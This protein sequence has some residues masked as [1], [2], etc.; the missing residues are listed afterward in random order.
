MLSGTLYIA[1]NEPFSYLAL[2]TS[3]DDYFRIECSDSLKK[4]L[5]QLQ[6]KYDKF[7]GDPKIWKQWGKEKPK[8]WQSLQIPQKKKMQAAWVSHAGVGSHVTLGVMKK[9]W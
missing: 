1:G 8:D 4:E 3:H 9:A 2:H 5:W 7:H 6:G